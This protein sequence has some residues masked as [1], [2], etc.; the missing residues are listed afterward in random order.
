MSTRTDG[1]RPFKAEAAETA[2][3]ALWGLWALCIS[4]LSGM[5][6]GLVKAIGEIAF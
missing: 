2:S 3:W 4:L 6:F 1:W 5:V